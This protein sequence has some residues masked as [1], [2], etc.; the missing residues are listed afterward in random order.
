MMMMMMMMI[1]Y[2]IRTETSNWIDEVPLKYHWTRKTIGIAIQY[3]HTAR[4]HD[5]R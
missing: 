4:A 5:T 1:C 3:S 2:W